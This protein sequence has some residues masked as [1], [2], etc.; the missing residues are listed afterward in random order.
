MAGPGKGASG[1]MPKGAIVSS[2]DSS[3]EKPV[4][5][6]DAEA[7]TLPGVADSDLTL[8]GSVAN[9]VRPSTSPAES[10]ESS[11]AVTV[12]GRV[13]SRPSRESTSVFRSIGATI[14]SDGDVLGGRYEITKLLG[15][16]GMGAV[17]KA[18]DMEVERTVGL[19]V[20]RPDL[21]EN[22]AILARFK[23]ELVLARQ[24]THKNI[25]RIYDL[26]EADGVKFITMEFIEGE[27]LRTILTR[28]G[29]LRPEEAVEILHQTCAGLN[30]AHAEGVIH[31]D[32][33]PANI[34]RDQ[35]GRVVIM[36]FGLARTLQGEGM[37]QTGMMVGTMEYMSPE[38]AKG[39]ELDA[40]S[41][42][43]AVGLIAYEM[44]TGKMPYAADSAVAS[45][46]KRSQERAKPMIDVDSS[47][48]RDLS[49]IVARCIEPDSKKR[50]QNTAEVLADL[51]DWQ[52]KGAPSTL[53][54]PDVRRWARDIPWPVI[55]VITSVLVL[56]VFGF[57]L[58]NKLLRP[59]ISA[60]P[61]PVSVLVADFQNKT[62]DPLFDDT[63]EPMFNVALEGASFINAYS[64][65]TA[66]QAAAKL[67]NPT[68]KLDENAARL[69]AVNEGVAAIVT[70]S[71]SSRGSGYTL[72]VKAIDAVTGKTLANA[73]V[74]TA[75][76]DELL[77]AV[78]K[79]A[80]PIREALG[81]TTP[82]S[83][84]LEK[85]AGAFS[86]SSLAAV[87]QYGIA[88]EQLWAGNSEEALKSFSNAIAL[89]PNFARA[90]GG[91]A[92]AYGNLGKTQEQEKYVKLAME[93]VDRMTERERYRV[94]GL[95]Y[96]A[97][98]NYPKCIEEYGE[99][100]KRFPADNI[101]WG[102][103]GSCYVNLRRIPEAVSAV[104]R[105]VQ[106][107]PRGALQ[108]LVLSF[109]SSYAGDFVGGEREARK[110]L[111]LS[112]SPSAYLALAEAQ[113]GLGQI[114]QTTETYQKLQEMNAEGASL[115]ASGLADL[116]SY[117]GRYADGVRI[118]EQGV[119]ADLAAKNTDNAAEKLGA[120]AQLQI[121]RGQKGPAVAAATRALA[122][123]QSV[124]VRLLV[125]R[126]LVE[127]GE[128]ARAQKIASSL[129]SEL[130]PEPQ[131][132]GKI[133]SGD[134]ALLRGDKNEAIKMF[135]DANQLL[136]TW[137][138]RFEL[139]RAYVEAGRFVEAD[140]EF[141]RC[142]KRRGEAI[143][144]FMDDVTTF[145]YFPPVYYY[146]GRVREGLKSPGFAESYRAYLGIR[147]KASEDPL[148]VDIRRRLQQ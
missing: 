113:L 72:S 93:H 80:A 75:N 110:A 24:I 68:G 90:Y 38:Q 114:P 142:M 7:R 79:L 71:L 140:S 138:G 62:A 124:P 6:V 8:P 123:S 17:Y 98:S 52:Q 2:G 135:T 91:M 102:N 29:K 104:Q 92:S 81:D 109:Y 85:A 63:L 49:N 27:D 12:A 89:D 82:E 48:S 145:A 46:L 61:A 1:R 23:Q 74:N 129:G 100:V 69:V 51:E 31:R 117:E 128:T 126:S 143:E 137:I 97:T 105:A 30:A 132:Y 60:A 10:V 131:A 134:L 146:Q 34:M 50:Y 112:P 36:D 73:D 107:T 101:A 127:A 37:T 56:A 55:G 99:L 94:R 3:T 64:R 116:A 20:I 59:K 108:R 57:L 42:I 16:G 25:I 40:T 13:G 28:Q 45:L 147:G 41:D 120:L 88:M 119:A 47:I 122:V 5:A 35:S 21:A 32:L 54:F 133:I 22:P 58:R 86:T 141:D 76:K 39:L 9:T 148:V 125:G 96:Y 15:M 43:Y 144:M 18:Y 26:N 19:K 44:L 95:Y 11:D 65:S 70:G 118:L 83:V 67:P 53:R 4:S 115:A 121:L 78:P 77:F 139:G 130:Q 103:M 87:H 14:F 66:R 136:D 111:E 33:K 106:I 84:Q